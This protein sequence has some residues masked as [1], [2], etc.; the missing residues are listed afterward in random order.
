MSSG[1]GGFREEDV[2]TLLQQCVKKPTN[3]AA[4]LT[5][6]LL[7]LMVRKQSKNNKTN[8][9]K[10]C[11]FCACVVCF[12]LLCVFFSLVFFLKGCRV[13]EESF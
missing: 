13:F 3:K 9:T 10:L 7:N 8:K 12:L 2:K 6:E 5:A 1:K 11:P 4:S